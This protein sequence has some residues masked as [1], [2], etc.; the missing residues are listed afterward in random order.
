V[1]IADLF[2]LLSC[3]W[4]GVTHEKLVKGQPIY[5]PLLLGVVRRNRKTGRFTFDGSVILPG[6]PIS[7]LVKRA[8]HSCENLFLFSFLTL[9]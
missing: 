8:Q 9:A 2:F 6:S 5:A 3:L 1:D 7:R 4:L